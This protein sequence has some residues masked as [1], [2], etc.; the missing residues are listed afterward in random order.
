[1]KDE[2]KQGFEACEA[3]SAKM[4]EV[5]SGAELEAVITVCVE[6]LCSSARAI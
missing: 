1:M 5:V 3:L 6:T 2:G 4:A